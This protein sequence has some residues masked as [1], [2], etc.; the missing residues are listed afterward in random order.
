MFRKRVPHNRIFVF[1]ILSRATGS[2]TYRG[3]RKPKD[4]DLQPSAKKSATNAIK[5]AAIPKNT[6]LTLVKLWCF[7]GNLAAKITRT[8]QFVFG[9]GHGLRGLK[10]V[11]IREIRGLKSFFAWFAFSYLAVQIP[12]FVLRLGVCVK[13]N[14]R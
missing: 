6:K 9:A 3:H 5:P 11:P 14:P 12:R 2:P 4:R 10:S 1:F 8:C 7:W 13:K